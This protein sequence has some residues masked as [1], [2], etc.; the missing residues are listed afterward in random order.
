ME[1]TE[2]NLVCDFRMVVG[3]GILLCVGGLE[4]RLQMHQR[5]AWFLR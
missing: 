4:R 5:I 2:Y 1:G 3:T